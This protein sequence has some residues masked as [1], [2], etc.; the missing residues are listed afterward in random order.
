ME[1]SAEDW[2][3]EKGLE[4]GEIHHQVSPLIEATLIIKKTSKQKIT[5]GEPRL[6]QRQIRPSSNGIT[7][8]KR[9]GSLSHSSPCKQ[10][11][12]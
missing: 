10:K 5:V 8:L 11:N 12:P 1:L 2:G 6:K 4:A 3:T 9:K 7:E